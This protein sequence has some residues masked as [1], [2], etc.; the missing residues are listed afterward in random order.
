M[1]LMEKNE[2]Y[3]PINPWI[4]LAST[5]TIEFSSE[6]DTEQGVPVHVKDELECND[7]QQANTTAPVEDKQTFS[8][9]PH[10]SFWG[11]SS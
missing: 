1:N 9:G 10:T 11:C 5:S 4:S 3:V 2:E 6:G 7:R 8:F